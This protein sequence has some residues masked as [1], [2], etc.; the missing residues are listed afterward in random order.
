MAVHTEEESIPQ[1]MTI[2]IFSW[3][4]IKS[5]MRFK[6]VSK[7]YNS[8]VVESN[9]VDLHLFHYFKINGGDTMLI[10]CIKDVCYAIEEHDEDGNATMHQTE[11]LFKLYN[12]INDPVDY[13]CF[14]CDNGLFCIWDVKYNEWDVKYIAICNPTTKEGE[15]VKLICVG[16][17][18]SSD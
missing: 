2:Q 10:A 4:P 17:L 11:N 1:D 9:F 8:L 15:F 14:E 5:L 13:N 3:L 18:E 6:C 12:H 7:F 16:T